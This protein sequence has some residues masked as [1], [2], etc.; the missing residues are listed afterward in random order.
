M[1]ERRNRICYFTAAHSPWPHRCWLSRHFISLGATEKAGRSLVN[2]ATFTIENGQGRW[3]SHWRLPLM[4]GDMSWKKDG[5]SHE[6]PKQSCLAL[7]KVCTGFKCL[8]ANVNFFGLH[9]FSQKEA[10]WKWHWPCNSG[11]SWKTI[12]T[13]HIIITH[14]C[15]IPFGTLASVSSILKFLPRPEKQDKA[16]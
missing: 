11:T 10:T 1:E 9:Y 16:S 8:W 14:H 3:R 12:I 2:S 15:S 6:S 5:D 4:L 13:H 7:D